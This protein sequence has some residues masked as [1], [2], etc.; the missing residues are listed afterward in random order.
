MIKYLT[1][2]NVFIIPHR[3]RR[4]NIIWL[5][6]QQIA[7]HTTDMSPLNKQTYRNDMSPT[8][9]YTARGRATHRFI[10]AADSDS[11]TDDFFVDDAYDDVYDDVYDVANDNV[12]EDDDIWDDNEEDE[13]DD[14]PYAF[15][16]AGD[17]GESN[18]N[19]CPSW[20]ARVLED[21][22]YLSYLSYL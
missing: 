16:G 5:K 6:S 10:A 2:F 15:V 22:S 14:D 18:C 21:L 11:D 13:D 9:K 7:E 19:R 20:R 8:K 3:H 1:H 17:A 12:D 4:K